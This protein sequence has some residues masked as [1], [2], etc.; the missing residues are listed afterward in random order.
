MR[1]AVE[2]RTGVHPAPDGVV[3]AGAMEDPAGFPGHPA[4]SGVDPARSMEYPFCG[5]APPIGA[6]VRPIS[7]GKGPAGCNGPPAVGLERR[8]KSEARIAVGS[9][10]RG[11]SNTDRKIAGPP[12]RR[13][14]TSHAPR[15]AE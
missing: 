8:R 9:G 10:G 1:A 7:R 13:S 14:T 2:P 11:D 15:G 3:P 12:D 4:A 5:G 6:G